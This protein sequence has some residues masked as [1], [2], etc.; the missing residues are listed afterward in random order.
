M[1]R[2][3]G[4]RYVCDRCGKEAFISY[5]PLTNKYGENTG[6]WMKVATTAHSHELWVCSDCAL[7]FKDF[8]KDY[9][10]R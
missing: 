3:E 6:G 9:L 5:S 1:P 2:E 7:I 10:S 4:V 8:L